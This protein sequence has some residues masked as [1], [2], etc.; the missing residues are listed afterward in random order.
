MKKTLAFISA[1]L[2][3]AVSS[4][5]LPTEA[6]A[7]ADY[8]SEVSMT[9]NGM[10]NAEESVRAF[11]DRLYNLVLG[12]NPDPSGFESWTRQL[13]SGERTAA[14]VSYGIIFSREY[15]EKE[16]SD[17]DYV[18]MMYN[19]MMNR[20]PDSQGRVQ[21]LSRL[22]NNMS[23]LYIFCSFINS[24][25]FS[26]ICSDY[27]IIRGD[28]SPT[29]NRDKN[30]DVTAFVNRLYRLCLDRTPDIA[31]LNNWCG[32]LNAK[33]Q[34]A[35]EAVR[36]FV[37][38]EEFRNKNVSN[39]EYV[40][41]MYRTLLD[42]EADSQGKAHWVS[43]LEDGYSRTA[44]L[45]GFVE[46]SEFSALCQRYGIERGSIN[47]GGWKKNSDGF[48]IYYHTDSEKL[49]KGYSKI[50]GVNYYF[51]DE[52]ILRTDWSRLT[53]CVNTS[54]SVYSYADMINDI[55]QLQQQYPSLVTVRTLGTTADRRQICDMVIGNQDAAKQIVIQAGSY[56]TEYMGSMLVMNQAEE[57]LSCY[58]NG[59]YSGRSYNQLLE[60]YQIHVIPMLNP[61]GIALSQ[62]GFDAIR[63]MSVRSRIMEIY[64]QDFNEGVTKTE[65]N[66]YLR[67]WKS[68]ALG[69]DLNR[70]FAVDEWYEQDAAKR[71]G[72][73]MYPGV[74]PFSENETKAV[75][76]LVD[77][78]ED[79]RAV[80]S[81]HSSGSI[82][83]WKYHQTGE[84]ND[85]CF[86]IGSALKN[87]TGYALSP[88]VSDAGGF[89]NWAA[90]VKKIPAFTIKTGNGNPPLEY[91][92]YESIWNANKNVIPY[93]LSSLG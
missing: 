19:V 71:P 9:E 68:N 40:N 23:R 31:G 29:E 44:V 13:L 89:S 50:D 54:S 62:N 7:E 11:V 57:L 45:R 74:S 81:Y 17:E 33:A 47:I 91:R 66:E 43:C 86:S 4:G 73:S 82:I 46:S 49:V 92:E 76:G 15:S 78:L 80:I 72:C 2:I 24:S 70:N 69:V 3:M 65:L 77:S 26:R 21:W 30:A 85:K 27:G 36:G 6:A 32:S 5:Y 25:E 75:S 63:S 61:D 79:C 22:S 1:F 35:A 18:E 55:S 51:D 64:R 58:W 88:D 28:I 42:R 53:K 59:S 60:D 56:A 34:T 12:R 93:L 37:S 14:Q 16:T 84:F 87:V 48:S 38:S 39:E 10:K 83:N 20:S 41:I 67:N 90:D 8:S 52:G